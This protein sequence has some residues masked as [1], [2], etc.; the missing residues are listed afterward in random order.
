[1]RLVS[2][3]VIFLFLSLILNL[4]FKYQKISSLSFEIENMKK[5]NMQLSDS[6][7]FIGQGMK[8]PNPMDSLYQLGKSDFY[9]DEY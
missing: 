7:F 6:L 2:V 8:N 3:A 4:V 9:R 1:M 5:E